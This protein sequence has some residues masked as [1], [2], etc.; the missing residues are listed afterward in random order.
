LPSKNGK[1]VTFF[2]G[3][4]ENEKIFAQHKLIFAGQKPI[5]FAQLKPNLP[6]HKHVKKL[7]FAVK[8]GF[9]SANVS[10]LS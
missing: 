7:L 3:L 4:L 1:F 2:H 6:Q 10:F 9:C 5:F 8:Y